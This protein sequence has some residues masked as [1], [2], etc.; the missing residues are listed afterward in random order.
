M[1][2]HKPDSHKKLRFLR[3]DKAEEIKSQLK[4]EVEDDAK[5]TRTSRNSAAKH[6]EQAYNPGQHLLHNHNSYHGLARWRGCLR[7]FP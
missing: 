6:S 4:H 3:A 7:F 5:P 1:G 2:V